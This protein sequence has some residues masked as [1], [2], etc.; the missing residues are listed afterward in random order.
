[1]DKPRIIK[2]TYR[3]K[4]D[5]SDYESKI[6]AEFSK[7]ASVDV[8]PEIQEEQKTDNIPLHTSSISD[9]LESV[10]PSEEEEEIEEATVE[11]AIQE[12]PDLEEYLS[13]EKP[14]HQYEQL[15][16]SEENLLRTIVNLSEIDVFLEHGFFDDKYV[17]PDE[18]KNI[19]S[20]V[21]IDEIIELTKR[22]KTEG[23][24]KVEQTGEIF[25]YPFL[26]RIALTE[27]GLER[28][29]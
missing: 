10:F 20:S 8:L 23:L 14:V 28:I 4:I 29:V 16:L 13:E 21:G 24:L 12:M 17:V 26:K 25:A 19:F 11:A 22:L 2:R 1:M 5:E 7:D 27:L 9:S 15:S 18:F 3:L 6:R